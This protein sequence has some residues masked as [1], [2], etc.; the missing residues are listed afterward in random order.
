MH[1]ACEKVRAGRDLPDA[2]LRD[3]VTS[4]LGRS[5]GVSF[6]DVAATAD[7]VGRS[8]LATMLLEFEPRIADQVRSAARARCMH[9][10]T[11]H[12]PFPSPSAL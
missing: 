11:I 12:C 3:M 9:V 8:D 4:R 5:S 6:A 1:W 7:A 2:T 10:H